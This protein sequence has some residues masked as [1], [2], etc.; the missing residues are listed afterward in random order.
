MKQCILLLLLMLL[1]GADY[2]QPPVMDSTWLP[3]AG[4]KYYNYDISLDPM[5]HMA[6][7]NPHIV[8]DTGANVTWDYNSVFYKKTVPDDSFDFVLPSTRYINCANP[9]ANLADG[10][11]A[12]FTCFIKN[13]DGVQ[14]A[15]RK[16]QVGNV[17]LKEYYIKPETLLKRNFRFHRE[18]NDTSNHYYWTSAN[19]TNDSPVRGITTIY[20]KYD[21]YGKLKIWGQEYDTAVR[22][23]QI[24]VTHDTVSGH[25][26]DSSITVESVY[27]WYIPSVHCWKLNIA[28]A[29]TIR[30]GHNTRDTIQRNDYARITD[31]VPK[32]NIAEPVK[33]IKSI[34]GRFDGDDI[35]LHDISNEIVSYAIYNDKGELMQRGGLTR[36]SDQNI[37]TS[38]LVPGLYLLKISGENSEVRTLKLVKA[39]GR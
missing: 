31:I 29:F 3:S 33:I 18:Y 22:V 4:D 36:A 37:R 6:G 20:Q 10:D 2:A 27:V 17:P 1:Y 8:N 19:I 35:V 23:H 32:S 30:V 5:H 39:S 13:A 15:D 34:S 28:T 11:S 14:L 16:L 25:S 26:Y 24:L 9:F 7:Y 12:N 38:S 21:G